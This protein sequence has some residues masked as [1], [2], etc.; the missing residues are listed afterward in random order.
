MLNYS[1]Y[2][3]WVLSWLQSLFKQMRYCSRLLLFLL[4]SI[5]TSPICEALQSSVPRPAQPTSRHAVGAEV[6]FPSEWRAIGH[7]LHIQPSSS[8]AFQDALMKPTSD[9]SYWHLAQQ[10]GQ[11]PSKSSKNSVPQWR[12]QI[13]TK[14]SATYNR[15]GVLP[16]LVTRDSFLSQFKPPWGAEGC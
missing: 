3:H 4:S 9:Y 16:A 2:Q 5:W 11:K 15:V 13:T 12:A 7:H 1:R 6:P 8:A 14:S 10:R